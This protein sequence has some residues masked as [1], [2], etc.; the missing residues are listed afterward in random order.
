MFPNILRKHEILLILSQHRQLTLHEN[1]GYRRLATF[2]ME[3]HAL[4]LMVMA[5]S[6]STIIDKMNH[7]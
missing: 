7:K 4:I 1:D 6:N 2:F 3:N 5:K